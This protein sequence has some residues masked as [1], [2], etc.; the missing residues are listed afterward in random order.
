MIK[1]MGIVNCEIFCYYTFADDSKWG[2]E[3]LCGKNVLQRNCSNDISS[4]INFSIILQKKGKANFKVILSNMLETETSA[5]LVENIQ[6][7]K[8]CL[9][10]TMCF[11]CKSTCVI[12]EEMHYH[13][14]Q[15]NN[16]LLC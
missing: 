2:M 9:M 7:K 12:V 15:K 1:E 4:K 3:T 8:H 11:L 16:L 14:N 5:A 13:I 6:L 10:F